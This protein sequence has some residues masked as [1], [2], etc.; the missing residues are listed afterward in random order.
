MVVRRLAFCATL[1]MSIILTSSCAP[2]DHGLSGQGSSVMITS[3]NNGVSFSTKESNPVTIS[4]ICEKGVAADLVATPARSIANNC[5]ADGTWSFESG[6]L[7]G[8]PN[9]FTISISGGGGGGITINVI[10]SSMSIRADK[11]TIAVGGT[12]NLQAIFFDANGAQIVMPYATSPHHV[13]WTI[14]NGGATLSSIGAPTRAA[15]SNAIISA[16]NPPSGPGEKTTV[17]GISGGP[18]TIEAALDS[19]D[20]AYGYQGNTTA[21]VTINVTDV[22]PAPVP[23]VAASMTI[24]ADKTTINVGDTA[25]L[26]VHFFDAFGAEI[27]I[28]YA[29]SSHDIL[30]TSDDPFVSFTAVTPP[31]SDEKVLITGVAGGTTNVNAQLIGLDPLYGFAGSTT[32]SIPITVTGGLLS[33]IATVTSAIYTVSAGGTASETITDVPFGTSKATFEAALTPDDPN[34]SWNDSGIEDPVVYGDTLVVTAQDGI[35]VVLYT[36][37]V[38]GPPLSDVATVTSAVY[39]VS[40]GGTASETITDVPFATSKA[41]FE[42]A[43]TKGDI[44]ESWD[45]TAIEDP[46]ATGDVLVVTAQ[47]GVTAVTYTVTVSSPIGCGYPIDPSASGFQGG[48][49]SVHNPYLICTAAQLNLIG[50]DATLNTKSFKLGANIDLAG[51]AYNMIGNFT[52]S[53]D[54]DNHTIS[55]LT[56]NSQSRAAF[57]NQL[58]S[59]GLVKNLGLENVNI[60]TGPSGGG[61]VGINRGTITNSYVTGA[62]TGTNYIGG[63]AGQNVTAITGSYAS[64]TVTAGAGSQYVGGLVG[65][66]NVP[67][68]GPSTITN[69]YATGTVTTGAGSQYVGGLVGSN[70]SGGGVITNSY[71]TGTV[72][73]GDGSY[74]VGGLVGINERN[75]GGANGTIINSYASGAVMMAEISYA[76]N[77]GGLVGYNQGTITGSCANGAV[78]I[79]STT[80]SSGYWVGGLTGT[81]EGLVTN[82][83]ATG[84]ITGGYDVGGLAGENEGTITG[85]YA[86]GAVIGL[87]SVG[88]LVGNN[89][90]SDTITS[91]YATGAVTGNTAVGGLV[92]ANE[93]F[94]TIAGSYATG[95]VIGTGDYYAGGLVGENI[96]PITDSYATGAVTG[97]TYVGGLVGDNYGQYN[98]GNHMGSIVRSYATGAVTGNTY[99][100]GLVGENDEALITNAYAVGSVTGNDYVGGLVGQSSYDPLITNVYAAGAVSGNTNWVGGLAGYSGIC[101]NC[102]WDIQTSGQQLPVGQGGPSS[103]TGE[104]TAQMMQQATFGWD[105]TNVWNIHE[106]A[107]YPFLR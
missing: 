54:G 68:G 41:D 12:A 96:G 21:D 11:T 27:V 91:S 26:R 45:D 94:A 33:N 72:I 37:V 95:E 18:V 38:A 10:A 97:N 64:V 74:Y 90:I 61:L 42:T 40:A 25:N 82:S 76:Y 66:T 50:S 2:G 15:L 56:I 24:T 78:T 100:G 47:D 88:G 34:E 7:S 23:G 104:N 53:F 36:I 44:N 107:S 69:S 83:C 59:G 67:S 98:I 51:V 8:G 70:G 28:P 16:Y 43:L 102:Y 77:I 62:V 6:V 87:S 52:G 4:G 32:A 105:F 20:P 99:V 14:L 84:T 3:P 75:N 29:T 106:G 19:V 79:T 22:A 30:W 89:D 9:T 48:N 31:V 55:N 1:L 13:S 86:I 65:R 57:I 80:G 46:V 39:T 17:T 92:G 101:T 5:A 81:N 85:S 49:G 60:V 58:R 103:G 93:T 63:L 73:A 71:A 35:T